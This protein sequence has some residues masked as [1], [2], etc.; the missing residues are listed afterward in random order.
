[1]QRFHIESQNSQVYNARTATNNTNWSQR[2]SSPR[3]APATP[4]RVNMQNSNLSAM[5]A[6]QMNYR[7]VSSGSSK[8]PTWN[9]NNGNKSNKRNS[10]HDLHLLKESCNQSDSGISS[11]SPT[12]NRH[13]KSGSQNDSSDERDSLA[14]EGKYNK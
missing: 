1:M 14:S 10:Y 2:L 3:S 6:S 4:R 7:P 11:R 12:P 5:P 8:K 13:Y 9:N